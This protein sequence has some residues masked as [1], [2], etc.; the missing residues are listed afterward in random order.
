MTG[1]RRRRSRVTGLAGVAEKMADAVTYLSRVADDAGLDRIS[2]DLL[3]IRR[4]L[5]VEAERAGGGERVFSSRAP[6]STSQKL[7]N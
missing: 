7:R 6:R 1:I 5:H 4:R 2:A 3:S